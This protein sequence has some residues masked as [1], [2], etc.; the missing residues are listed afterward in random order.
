MGARWW[1]KLVGRS[2]L[3]E[4]AGRRSHAVGVCP[5]CGA[6]LR[7]ASDEWLDADQA[8][9]DHVL[10]CPS[11]KIPARA[12]GPLRPAPQTLRVA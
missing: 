2:L 1:R 7:V 6:A 3:R 8:T 5:G 10:A 12:T 9:I 4:R 11:V